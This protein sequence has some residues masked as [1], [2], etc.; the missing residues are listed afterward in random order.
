ME[1]SSIKL[2][3]FV[4]EIL[5]YAFLSLTAKPVVKLIPFLWQF[6]S[7]LQCEICGKEGFINSVTLQN[8]VRTKHSVDRPFGCEYCSAKYATAMSLSGHR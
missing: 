2:V 3:F 4:I 8:H 6:I 7:C 1:T 5:T